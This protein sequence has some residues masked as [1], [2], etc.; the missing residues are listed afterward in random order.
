LAEKKTGK[1]V[2]T[3]LLFLRG[4]GDHSYFGDDLSNLSNIGRE[5]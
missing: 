3:N 2:K 5:K 1:N 4:E